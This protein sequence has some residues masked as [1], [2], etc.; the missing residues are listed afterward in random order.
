MAIVF[1][2]TLSS[3]QTRTSGEVFFTFDKGL[4]DIWLI[5]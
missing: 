2:E 3:L 5:G 4:Y 1:F